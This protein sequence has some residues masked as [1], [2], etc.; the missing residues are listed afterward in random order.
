MKAINETKDKV[1]SRGERKIKGFLDEPMCP[2]ANN[3]D[4][5]LQN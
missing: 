2:L 3:A 5:T 4:L 1:P